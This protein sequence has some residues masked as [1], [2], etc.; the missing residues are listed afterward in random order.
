MNEYLTAFKIKN[1]KPFFYRKIR[2]YL[3]LF[4]D[5]SSDE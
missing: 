3:T 4:Y 5:K 1:Q 2:L